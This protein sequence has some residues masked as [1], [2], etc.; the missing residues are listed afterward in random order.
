MLEFKK[1]L[2]LQKDIP[3]KIINEN[4]FTNIVLGTQ[5]FKNEILKKY[6]II[7][8]N[9]SKKIFKN[10]KNID[11]IIKIISDVFNIN[12]SELTIKKGKYNH[13][14]KRQYI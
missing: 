14:K 4:L 7:D 1:F 11:E 8:L 10:N 2:T 13:L 3:D 12:Y 6:K 5:E 9:I